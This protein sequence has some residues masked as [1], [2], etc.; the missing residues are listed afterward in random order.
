MSVEDWL[1]LAL[2]RLVARDLDLLG[3]FRVPESLTFAPDASSS[4]PS[5]TGLTG[6]MNLQDPQ[7][8]IYKE[9]SYTNFI[10]KKYQRVTEHNNYYIKF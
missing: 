5:A 3:A 9:T 8:R 1:E 7:D 6:D 4:G 10:M 2:G